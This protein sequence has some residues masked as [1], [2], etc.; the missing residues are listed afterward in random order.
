VGGNPELTVVGNESVEFIQEFALDP[1]VHVK[2]G[3]V[4]AVDRVVKIFA[5][6][7]QI[8]K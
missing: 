2:V 6:D 3:L 7:D 8:E 5:L 4:D 1:S